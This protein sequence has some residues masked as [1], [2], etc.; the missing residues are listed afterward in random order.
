MSAIGKVHILHGVPDRKGMEPGYRYL[1][2]GVAVGW[3]DFP[4]FAMAKSDTLLPIRS[5]FMS[6]I[7]KHRQI[8]PCAVFTRV[9]VAKFS[10]FLNH[11]DLKNE[12]FC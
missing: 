2:H 6:S 8:W 1:G 5:N 3:R 10:F 12:N 4:L 7:P 11:R 9:S